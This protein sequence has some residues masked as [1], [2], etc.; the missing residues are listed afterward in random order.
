MK[1]FLALA[2]FLS[3]LTA[4]GGS[5]KIAANDF[6]EIFFDA[7]G[8]KKD[9]GIERNSARPAGVAAAG[10]KLFVALGNLTIDCLQPAGPGY[11]AVI[12]LETDG[13]S[14]AAYRLTELPAACRNPQNVLANAD[15]T[16]VFVSCSG[17]FGYGETPSEAV[18]AVDTDTEQPLFTVR[19]GCTELDSDDCRPAT[20][21]KMAFLAD[22]SLLVGDSGDGRIFHFDAETGAQDATLRK[23]LSI[24]AKHPEL[25]WQMTGDIVVKNDGRIFA[26]CFTTSELMFLDDKFTVYSGKT[27]GSGAQLLALNGEQLLIGD[28]MDNALY[29]MNV[30][31]GHSDLLSGGDRLGKAPNQIIV[32]DGLAYVIASQ[33]NV[34]QVIDLS[35]DRPGT[36]GAG[37]TI[38]QIP[39]RTST[40]ADATNTNPYLG[41]IEGDSLYVTLLGSCTADG[42]AAGNRIVRVGI[43][44]VE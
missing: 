38:Q 25:G 2:A 39:T 6:S 14:D 3:L 37:R 17:Q 22:G 9:A 10:G 16:R 7:S 20:P 21:G 41:T 8:L 30:A 31:S 18:V 19:L 24:C 23:G 36:L 32:K 44:N 12:D 13:K 26:T 5:D 34:I 15:G 29:S 4:C 11:L 1:R 43:G 42:D 40:S 28:S 35:K 33:D 27:I